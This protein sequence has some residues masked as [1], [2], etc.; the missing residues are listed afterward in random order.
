PRLLAAIEEYEE[1]YRRV[2]RARKYASLVYSADAGDPR[3]GALVQR[4]RE[5]GSAIRNETL[6]FELE[7][8][9][10][11]DDQFARLAADPRLEPYRHY[12]EQERRLRPYR[13]SEAEEKV[14]E[15]QANSGVRAWRRLF[16]E[17]LAIT[18]FPVRVKDEE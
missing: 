13:L 1:L 3:H 10:L 5:W 12:F 18:L 8:C 17:T 11:P 6:F 2:G 14:L 16:D 4:L 15:E 9:A 7:L